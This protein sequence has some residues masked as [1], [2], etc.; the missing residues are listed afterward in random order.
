MSM[1]FALEGIRD[2]L[3]KENDWS[4]KQCTIQHTAEPPQLAKGFHIALDDNGVATSTRENHYLQEQ[5]AVIVGVWIEA[6]ITPADYAGTLQLAESIYQKGTLTLN[7]IERLVITQIHQQNEPR[8]FT[9]CKFGLPG[10]KGDIFLAPMIY[11]GRG[12]NE[13]IAS[14][15]NNPRSA[16]WLGRRLRFSGFQRNQ[17]IGCAR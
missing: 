15:Q 12:T 7:D 1:A 9:N 10:E 2:F 13:T 3:R 5:Y 6:A 8:N 11:D 16:Q 4:V 17:K 14:N